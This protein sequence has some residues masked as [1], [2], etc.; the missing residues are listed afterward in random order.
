MSFNYTAYYQRLQDIKKL[1]IPA[2]A[3]RW[4]EQY[5]PPDCSYEIVLYLGCNILRTPDIAAEECVN[6]RPH[7]F[8]THDY[9]SGGRG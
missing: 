7:S 9:G 3:V 2:G 1:Q 8:L 4:T 5:E 6:A